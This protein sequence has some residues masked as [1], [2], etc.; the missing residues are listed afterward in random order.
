VQYD[1]GTTWHIVGGNTAWGIVVQFDI[2]DDK[3]ILLRG[4][5]GNVA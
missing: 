5:K 4:L 3:V 1:R 2:G